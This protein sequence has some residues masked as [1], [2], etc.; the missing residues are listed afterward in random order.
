MATTVNTYSRNSSG[1]YV[2]SGGSQTVGTVAS[3]TGGY[4]TGVTG[5]TTASGSTY[6]NPGAVPAGMSIADYEAAKE[7]AAYDQAVKES[8]F[9]SQEGTIQKVTYTE[10]EAPKP[11]SPVAGKDFTPAQQPFDRQSMSQ[12]QPAKDTGFLKYVPERVKILGYGALAGQGLAPERPDLASPDGSKNDYNFGQTL[13]LITSAGTGRLTVTAASKLGASVKVGSYLTRNSGT[14]LRATGVIADTVGSATVL[15]GASKVAFTAQEKTY[16]RLGGVS[17]QSVQAA[18]AFSFEAPIVGTVSSK[19]LQPLSREGL[20]AAS[21][22]GVNRATEKGGQALTGVGF[23]VFGKQTISR[24]KL[25]SI[26]ATSTGTMGVIETAS[27]VLTTRAYQKQEVTRKD[28]LLVPIGGGAAG[29]LGGGIATKTY[30]KNAPLRYAIGVAET[31]VNVLDPAEKPGDLLEDYAQYRIMSRGGTVRTPVTMSTRTG[32]K[33]GVE[34]RSQTNTYTKTTVPTRSA[35]ATKSTVDLKSFVATQTR[36]PVTTSSNSRSYS[37][38]T[39][40]TQQPTKTYTYTTTRSPVTTSTTT[41]VTT[42]TKV[43]TTTKVANEFFPAFI[44]PQGGGLGAG[45][46]GGRGSKTKNKYMPDVTGV[47]LQIK[48]RGKKA[49]GYSGLEVRGI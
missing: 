14:A 23:E 20:F 1:N 22:V 24:G 49:T 8:N 33:T 27:D 34:T 18:P 38:A 16:N 35:A 32:I 13:G 48:A 12:L 7:K 2:R 45:G 29:V 47:F 10:V 41:P 9:S 25:F 11:F 36:T 5:G 6:R 39:T 46:G 15:Y 21:I 42:S 30:I 28:L 43:T 37:M 3:P 26:T 4:V 31:S 19:F 40:Q 17:Y 44:P